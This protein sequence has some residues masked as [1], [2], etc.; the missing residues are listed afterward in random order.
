MNNSSI[1]DPRWDTLTTDDAAVTSLVSALNRTY[2]I[3][4]SPITASLLVNRGFADPEDVYQFL[5]PDLSQMA[6]PFLMK[7]MERAVDA[8]MDAVSSGKKIWVYG[9]YDVDGIT[10][11]SIIVLFF[12]SLGIDASYYIPDR[13]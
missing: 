9:D 4:I 5:H 10:S 13:V 3:T 1:S 7:D 11:V 12:R 2:S 8:I 6:D